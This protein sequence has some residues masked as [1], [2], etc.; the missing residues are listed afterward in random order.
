MATIINTE[1]NLNNSSYNFRQISKLRE[2]HRIEMQPCDDERFL[3]ARVNYDLAGEVL[4]V[5]HERAM[6][7]QGKTVKDFNRKKTVSENKN[8]SLGEILFL[9]IKTITKIS[10][11][12]I[13]MKK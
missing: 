8:T 2:K 5:K 7:I 13:T 6:A 12:T 11:K 3:P 9:I 4:R 10:W 1:L